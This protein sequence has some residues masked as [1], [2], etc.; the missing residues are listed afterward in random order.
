MQQLRDN[1]V[2]AGIVDFFAQ[3]DHAIVQQ[4]GE[5]VIAALAPGGL[6]NYIGNQ[7]VVHRAVLQIG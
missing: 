1:H 7:S 4:A 3:E 5:D 2:G 6:L